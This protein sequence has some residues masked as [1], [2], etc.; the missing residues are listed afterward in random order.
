MTAAF[1]ATSVGGGVIILVL[2][3]H[4][5]WVL[6]AYGIREVYPCMALVVHT[7]PSVVHLSRDTNHRAM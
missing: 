3:L 4:E 2:T 5:S 7:M 6:N 1:A